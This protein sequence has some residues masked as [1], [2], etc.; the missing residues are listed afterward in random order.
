MNKIKQESIEDFTQRRG[1]EF[2]IARERMKLKGEI[3]ELKMKLS[4][5]PNFNKYVNDLQD[6]IRLLESDNKAM[7]RI[8]DGLREENK[9]LREENSVKN[10]SNSNTMNTLEDLETKLKNC[11][12][13]S[14]QRGRLIDEV[15]KFNS[16]SK[17]IL[18]DNNFETKDQ[19]DKMRLESII[20]TLCF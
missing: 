12:S 19:K 11:T 17:Q 4:E 13:S 15:L 7:K 20:N 6:K 18:N 10:K 5:P 14:S 16:K 3:N 8:F 2:K 1:K 9:K